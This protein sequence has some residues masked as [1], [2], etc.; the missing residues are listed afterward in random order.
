M[1]QT[2]YEL[3]YYF[4]SYLDL[5]KLN[6]IEE[7]YTRTLHTKASGLVKPA[8]ILIAANSPNSDDILQAYRFNGI[9]C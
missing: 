8:A 9:I 1:K 3:L 7:H 4:M 2:Y 6:S 5:P